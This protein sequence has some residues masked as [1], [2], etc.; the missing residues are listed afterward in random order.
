MIFLTEIGNTIRKASSQDWD[1]ISLTIK[2]GTTTLISNVPGRYSGGYYYFIGVE[3]VLKAYMEKNNLW[4]LAI[5]GT[6]TEV[7]SD[8]E[9][10]ATESLSTTYILFNAFPIV[11]SKTAAQISQDYFHT[12]RNKAIIYPGQEFKLHF[13]EINQGIT[14]VRHKLDGTSYSWS[15]A[16]EQGQEYHD[17]AYN[18]ATA[19]DE[20]KINTS[21]IFTL[22]H[23]AADNV[24]HFKF[25]NVFN[26]EETVS[27]PSAITS[28]PS[29]EFEEARQGKVAIRYDIEHKTEYSLKASGVPAIVCDALF[30]MF[31]SRKVWSKLPSKFGGSYD[32]WRQIIITDY[33]IERSSEPNGPKEVEIKFY[34]ADNNEEVTVKM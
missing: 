9:Q 6:Y 31:R 33:K 15:D 29:T 10:S 8:T 26:V 22:Y 21:T 23:V 27:V 4:E 17:C 2:R 28:S 34:V 30:D 32:T 3:E 7:D 12:P 25:I 11:S 20:K 1:T 13:D 14:T 19:Y 16:T 18:S 5:S 24:H